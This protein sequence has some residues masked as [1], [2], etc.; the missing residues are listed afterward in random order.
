MES[1]A[2]TTGRAS[3]G[4]AS[5]MHVS[6]R[7]WAEV[8]ALGAWLAA[9][10][11]SYLWLVELQGPG[12]DLS[13]NAPP[14]A[15][16]IYELTVSPLVTVPVALAAAVV[17]LGPRLAA[18]M[19]WRSLLLLAGLVA[20]A[21][22][23]ALNLADGDGSIGKP[24]DH[25]NEYLTAVPQVG[26]PGEFLST[27]DERIDD[28][29]VHVRG[30]PPGTV[31]ALWGLEQIGLGGS[32]AAGLLILL[33][34]SSTVPAVMIAAR[35]VA[36]PE[37]ARRAAP[38]LV[39]APAA[40]WIATTADALYMGVGAWAITATLLS[41]LSD[42]WRSAL[43]AIAGGLL[44]GVCLMFSYGLVL[45]GAI[46]FLLAVRERRVAPLA[47]ALAAIA[48]V[49]AVPLAAG[50]NWVDGF[51]LIRE[52]YVQSVARLR[53]YE[54]FVIANLAVFGLAIGPAT[55]TGLVRS[56]R[57]E[58]WLLVGGGLLMVAAA[59]LSG[60]SKAEVER[61]WLPFVPW[62]MLATAALWAR[63]GEL[64][65]LLA[66]QAALAIGIEVSTELIW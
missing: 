30:H 36:G 21:W 38:F 28:Y 11:V 41:I 5:P 50:F 6:R 25:M 64:R 23:L 32:T 63:L 9:L 22:P 2:A 51:F 56:R 40:I 46:P 66:A 62:V 18:T 20:L 16:G 58:A 17:W 1:A 59:D 55:L 4:P 35:A 27:F 61:I 29:S 24:L 3:T 42:G 31:V 13:V 8:L 10:V 37:L 52:E 19:P 33:V 12:A 47:I 39:M 43:L 15:G 49:L 14:L 54:L 48:A 65:V 44:F 45:L 26:S 57:R 60:M 7:R 34:A 53:P